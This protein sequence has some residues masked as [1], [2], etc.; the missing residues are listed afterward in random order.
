[1]KYELVTCWSHHITGGQA[2]TAG[3]R[4]VIHHHAL[5]Y[6]YLNYL[7]N[8]Y[9]WHNFSFLLS[10]LIKSLLIINER[11]HNFKVLYTT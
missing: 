11:L 5:H 2:G 4:P 3:T 10:M 6:Q 8:Y 7:L 9:N 1:M